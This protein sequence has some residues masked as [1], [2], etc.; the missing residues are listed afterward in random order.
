[1]DWL[2]IHWRDLQLLVSVLQVC[3]FSVCVCLGKSFVCVYGKVVDP[4]NFVY[5]VCVWSKSFLPLAE[6]EADSL[7]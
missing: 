1:M 3:V 4:D 6:I 2:C 7:F 5:F